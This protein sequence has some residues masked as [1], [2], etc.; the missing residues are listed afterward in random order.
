MFEKV[1]IADGK[2][3]ILE[4]P[5]GKDNKCKHVM[6]KLAH[7]F[8]ERKLP[9]KLSSLQLDFSLWCT[10]SL[11]WDLTATS[12]GSRADSAPIRAEQ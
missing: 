12:A 8:G 7:M 10:S 2:G 3:F 6:L 4:L 11:M 5:I 1:G 9:G